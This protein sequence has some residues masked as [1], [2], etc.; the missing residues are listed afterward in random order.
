MN[1]TNRV[2]KHEKQPCKN[3]KVRIKKKKIAMKNGFMLFVIYF[4]S[5]DTLTQNRLMSNVEF[6]L[7]GNLTWFLFL[8]LYGTPLVFQKSYNK[9]WIKI[10]YYF[11][12]LNGCS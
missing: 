3:E 2:K 9:F 1:I 5:A 12:H 6:F 4:H 10:I 11:I 7:G 8:T